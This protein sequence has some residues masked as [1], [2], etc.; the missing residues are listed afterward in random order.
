M[1]VHQA[2]DL[3]KAVS[4]VENAKISRPSVC[5]AIDTVL[6]DTT[7]APFFLEKILPVF[8]THK[9]EIY[10]EPKH[11]NLLKGYQYLHIQKNL[12]YGIEYLSLKCALKMVNNM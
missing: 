10:V 9:V 2:A 6:I 4:I 1:Y 11:A 8:Q 5:N 12:D 3:S 7:I